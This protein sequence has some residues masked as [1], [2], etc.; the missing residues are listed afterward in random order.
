MNG[1]IVR[2]S[3]IMMSN[4]LSRAWSWKVSWFYLLGLYGE[5]EADL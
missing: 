3:V 2:V 4:T 5:N 1:H